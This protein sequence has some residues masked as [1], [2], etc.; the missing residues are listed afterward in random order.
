MEFNE[1][2]YMPDLRSH[3]KSEMEIN[4]GVDTDVNAWHAG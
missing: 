4:T 3:K 1:K 2:V